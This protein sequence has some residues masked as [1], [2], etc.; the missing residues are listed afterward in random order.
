MIEMRTMNQNEIKQK[1]AVEKLSRLKVGALFMEMG[2]GKTKVAMDLIESK[3]NKTDYALWI[4]PYSIR[5]EIEAER[6]K[7]HPDL[8]IDIVG[9]ESIGQSSRIYLETFEKVKSHNSFVVVDE[10]LKIKNANAQRTKRILNMGEHAKY[11]LILNGTPVSRNV[12]DLYTQMKFLSPKILN[13][14][15]IEF[16][17][18][19]CE[20]YT[21][22]EMKGR[23]R[24]SV[25]IA[26][27][28]SI[29]EP[30]IFESSLDI[31]TKKN[32]HAVHYHIDVE[33]YNE[34]K[35]K[36]FAEYYNEFKDELNFDA[37]ATKLQK[38][39]TQSEE[40]KK[41][42]QE[43]IEGI[44]GQVIIFVKFLSSIPPESMRITGDVKEKDRQK[45]IERF[46]AGEFKELYITYGSGSFGLNLQF[47]HNTIFAEK[48]W[49][50]SQVDQAEART[51]RMG[52]SEDVNYYELF[53]CD[54]GLENLIRKNIQKKGDL[55]Q[56]VK[57]EIANTK[58]GVKEWVKGI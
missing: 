23:V 42:L 49:D 13:M 7:W 14:S 56:T 33:A 47:C 1:E 51:Y 50:F 55:L 10:S 21:R 37:F 57:K 5:G 3:K 15:Y 53:C 31:D 2:T 28:I 22:G 48:I 11:K 18:T 43:L 20:Y 54:S 4:C 45:I 40:K 24:K 41:A 27:L 36:L 8:D 29:I 34:E 6:Q 12:L 39:Y 58:G 9:C 17:D 26:H 52:Q 44:D 32:H 19:Y 16:K 38:Y 30:Y 25:N 46:R 35:D